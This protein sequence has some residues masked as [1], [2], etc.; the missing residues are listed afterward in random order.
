ML[1]FFARR[2]LVS[3]LVA[4][5]V[6]VVAFS[7]LRL[8]GDL[9]ALLAGENAKPEDIARIAHQYGLDQPLYAQ[10]LDWAGSALHGDL[11]RSLFSGE[12][13]AQLL[14]ERIGVT[15]TLAVGALIL[16][17][18]VAIPLGVLAAV[19][20]N[21]VID[22][23]ALSFATCGQAIPNFWF[24]LILIYVFGVMYRVFPIS[25]SD[26]WQHFI[27]PT[28]TLGFTAMPAFMRL[29]RTGMLDMLSSDYIRTARAKGLSPVSILFKHALR[30]AILP[31]VSVTA[32]QLGFL[33]GGSVIVESVFALN[34]IGLLAFR[35]ITSADFPVVQSILVFLSC[36]Y[37]LL[38]LLADLINAR[39]DPRI[40]L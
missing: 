20:A 21:T 8:S 30:N 3:V 27:L 26:S 25:G 39:L 32:V 11:G 5:T 29:T 18:A 4:L 12:P 2:L 33:L 38:T 9:A 28:I 36:G 31:I 37:I 16:A 6:S 7:F 10:Y 1:S 13:V 23:L 35:S 17:L 22:R 34:G 14:T 15:L 19:R 40:R 24:A